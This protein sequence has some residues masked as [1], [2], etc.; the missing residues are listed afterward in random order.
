MR[1]PRIAGLSLAG[2]VAA[3]ILAALAPPVS[4]KLE[5]GQKALEFK[6]KD[7][8]LEEEVDLGEHLGKKVILLDFG[9]I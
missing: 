6:A 8:L 9:S 5:E 3:M 2:A 4:A 1:L 7:F